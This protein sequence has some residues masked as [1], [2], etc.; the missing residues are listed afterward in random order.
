MFGSV[1]DP[2]S[3]FVIP[4][5]NCDFMMSNTYSGGYASAYTSVCGEKYANYNLLQLIRNN[6]SVNYKPKNFF[7]SNSLYKDG[8]TFEM[9]KV[10]KQFVNTGK[11]NSG[12]Q[13]GWSFS[14]SLSGYGE[15]TLGNI[16][17]KKN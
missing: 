5:K 16:S 4:T 10:A 12:K 8:S 11:L 3:N 17:L 15:N 1:N 14:V 2:K 13:L 7:D 9:S 6:S